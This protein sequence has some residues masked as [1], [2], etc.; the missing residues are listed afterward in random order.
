MHKA[1][2][3]ECEKLASIYPI[4]VHYTLIETQKA[5]PLGSTSSRHS[6]GMLV[7]S[8]VRGEQQ[9]NH[10]PAVLLKYIFLTFALHHAA[11]IFRVYVAPNR[12]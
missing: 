12:R 7:R 8:F 2:S 9:P 6:P 3:A 4:C 5:S 11:T 1:P 10:V